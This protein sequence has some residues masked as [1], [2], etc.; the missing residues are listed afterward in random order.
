MTMT[1]GG[2]RKPAKADCGAGAGR[3]RR[4]LMPPVSLLQGGHSA[5]NTAP[6]VFPAAVVAEAKV[7]CR[8]RPTGDHRRADG[9]FGSSVGRLDSR[10]G[11]EA[12]QVRAFARQMAQHRRLGA[13][14]L[15]PV[16]SRSTMLPSPFGL[17]RG[18]LTCV[19]VGA[20]VCVDDWA[21]CS[22]STS[23]QS[24]PARSI[25]PP[26]PSRCSSARRRRSRVNSSGHV[27]GDRRDPGRLHHPS[28]SPS[29]RCSPAATPAVALAG[30]QQQ[31]SG[32]SR[33]RWRPGPGS[34]CFGAGFGL[35]PRSG[36]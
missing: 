22:I 28:W 33:R 12:E 29:T 8:P 27:S 15:R 30:T 18:D 7:G 1:S 14:T 9:L 13:W 16:M 25:P 3:G 17:G 36:R 2:K 10:D 35:P 21:S 4:V 31:V 32:L 11:Q 34:S 5:R 20:C 26:P 23:E 19:R 24:M 6:R